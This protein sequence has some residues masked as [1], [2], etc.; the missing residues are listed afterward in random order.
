[1]V[2]QQL[3]QGNIL[4]VDDDLNN[5]KILSATLSIQGYV[6]QSAISGSMALRIARAT[7]PDL[8]LLDIKMPDM[9]GYEVCQQLKVDQLTRSIPVIFISAINSVVDKVKA[10]KVGGL[11]YISKPF[12]PEELLAR[13]E[14]QLRL[15]RLQKQLEEK[16][17]QLENESLSRQRAETAL[18]ASESKYRHLVETSQDIIWSVDLLGCITFIN[19]AV[20][21]IVG[22][23]PQEMIGSS[24]TDFIFP[25]R[26][27]RYSDLWKYILNGEPISQYEITCFTKNGDLVY[28][29]LN[30]TALRNEENKIISVTGTASNITERKL[31]EQA[32]QESA[33]KLRNHNLV[34]T[35]LAQNQV[36]YQGDLAAALSEIT[37]AGAKNIGVERAS[38]WLYNTSHSVVQCLN[39]FQLSCNQHTSFDLEL[40]VA[41]YP[42][43]FQALDKDQLIASDKPLEDPRTKELAQSYLRP[44]GIT[45]M[46]S[47]P[48]RLAGVAT[49]ILCLE[50]VG[51]AHHW[52]AEEQNF[53]RS[54]GNLVSLAL[55]GRARQAS[56]QKLASAFRSSPD[57]IALATFPDI[58]YIEVNDRFSS[59]FGYS[60]EEV[61]G[62]TIDEVNI[63]MSKEQYTAIALDLQHQRT[64]RNH[65]LNLCT[66]SGEIKTMLFSAE[67]IEIE[68]GQYVLATAKDITERKQVE[69]ALRE[70]AERERATTKAIQRIRQT[71]DLETIFAV[72]TQELRQVLNCDRVVVYRFNYDWSGGFVAESVGMGWLSL[73]EEHNSNANFTEGALQD[74]SCAVRQLDSGDNQVLDTYLQTTQGGSYSRGA[75]YLCVCDIYQ[76]GFQPCYLQLLE[77]FQ[78]QA[79]ITVPIFC[80]NQ[81]WGLLGSY[82]NS[83]PRQWQTGEISTVVQISNQLGVALQQSE[84][85]TQTQ[86]QSQALQQAAI[87]ADAANRAKSEF[88]ANMSHELRTPL[89]AILGFTQIMSHDHTLSSEHQQDL[90]IINRAGEHLLNLINDILEMSKIEAGRT[91]LNVTSFDLVSLLDNLQQMLHSRATA[92]GLKLLFEYAPHIPRYITTD[93][94]KLRQVLFN[95]L[96]NAIKFTDS[97]QVTLRVN[98][99]HDKLHRLLFEVE[100][101]GAGIAKEELNLLFEAFGQTETGRKSQQGTGL[102]LAISRKY[103]HMM[104]GEITVKSNLGVG[105]IFNFDIQIQLGSSPEVASTANSQI[106]ALAANQPEYRIL[107]VDDVLESRILLAKILSAIGFSVMEATN[108]TEAISIWYRWHPQAILMDMRMPVMDGYEATRQ[109]KAGNPHTI[110]IAL[111]A[112]AFNEERTAMLNAGCDDLINKPF[113]QQQLLEKL[114]QHLKVKYIYEQ[115][116][117][118]V[119]LKEKT[120]AE[121]LS[122]E[123]F[124]AEFAQMSTQWLSQLYHAA[125][126]CSDD[127]ILKLVDSIPEENSLLVN[128]FQDLANNFQFET[129]LQ[130]LGNR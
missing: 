17:A 20:K 122:S 129:I 24:W 108:G 96:G 69:E 112:S 13:V 82:Q 115:D 34:L 103:I 5:L 65:E 120:T 106:I 40:V 63:W 28:L 105:S 113:P 3:I 58:H 88:L 97:G 16:N 94:S 32:L 19:S 49:G 125:A 52:T 81:L 111:T 93:S 56:E 57:P 1:M 86:K 30:A 62:R 90:A 41:D 79:Y 68:G 60:R 4:I 10:F 127:L 44:N 61:V 118:I 2:L 54:L 109:I 71:L 126:Q 59:F 7:L 48:V 66:C 75:S 70:S 15:Q 9:D 119:K 123:E 14:N 98:S 51:I 117:Q 33:N 95:L 87:I 45:S 47:V 83:G 100:D 21:K 89:N 77:S 114:G 101:T 23:D 25:E 26:I 110:I 116:E 74:H 37:V 12:Q 84:L 55:E 85:L 128:V 38:V 124:R 50:Q 29:L 130:I 78:A 76:A 92:K 27:A 73:I 42:G 53:A 22:Y 67:L 39:V 64:I 121:I 72:T 107:V 6:V 91:T 80:G 43:Y 31:A 104:G 46:L 8:I 36:L 11:D 99:I 102:G 18:R 35:Q